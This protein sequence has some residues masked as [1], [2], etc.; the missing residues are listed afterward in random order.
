MRYF[1]GFA[2]KNEEEF[3]K[4]WLDR[5]DFSVSGFSY[6]AIKAFEY[7]LNSKNRVD[8]LILLSPA[9]FND[10]DEKFKKMQLLFFAKD[11]KRY[12]DSFYKNI[13]SNSNIDLSRYKS[14]GT[15]E[16]LKELLYYNWDMQ[17]LKDLKDRGVEVEVVLGGKDLI[18]DSLK[19][20]EF[21]QNYATVYYIKEANHLL[22]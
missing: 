12:M 7:V 10:K 3:F 1:N 19:A 22:M 2:L 14:D 6:G 18:I 16:E 17:K 15:K 8:R 9:F 13:S 5:S 21:F 20:K 4:F 11:K